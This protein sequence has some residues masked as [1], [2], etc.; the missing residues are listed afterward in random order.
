[1]TDFSKADNWLSFSLM[2][3]SKEVA[4]IQRLWTAPYLIFYV[5]FSVPGSHFAS[6]GFPCLVDGEGVSDTGR[7]F[8]GD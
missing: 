7:S 3:A 6:F 4:Y 5:L 2:P 8:I 1:M